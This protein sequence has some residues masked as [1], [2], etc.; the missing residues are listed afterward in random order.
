MPTETEEQ[1]R[2]RL[3][4]ESIASNIANLAKSVNALLGGPLRKKTLLVLLANSTGFPQSTVDRV[5]V[6]L[7]EMEKDWLK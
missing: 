4:V 7:S 1:K 5:L 6:A 2:N 3:A